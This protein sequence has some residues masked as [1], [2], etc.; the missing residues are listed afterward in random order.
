ML[1][2]HGCSIFSVDVSTGSETAP[3][4]Q[5]TAG[6]RPPRTGDVSRNSLPSQRRQIVALSNPCH[7]L[8][9]NVFLHLIWLNLSKIP[10]N[11]QTMVI[12]LLMKFPWN[13]HLVTEDQPFFC[14]LSTSWALRQLWAQPTAPFILG[15]FGDVFGEFWWLDP[16]VLG[17]WVIDIGWIL[18]NFDDWVL[19]DI[20]DDW[21]WLMMIDDVLWVID[22]DSNKEYWWWTMICLLSNE[23]LM[24]NKLLINYDVL[25][26]VDDGW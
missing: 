10:W 2:I 14:W 5:C 9:G 15:V 21:W 20:D 8:K 26:V 13:P 6:R 23:W 19:W 12:I 22:D 7:P 4:L 18:L 24:I 17:K 16:K 25:W 11:S 1:N 3:T